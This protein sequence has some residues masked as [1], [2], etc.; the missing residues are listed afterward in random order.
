MTAGNFNLIHSRRGRRTKTK[1]NNNNNDGPYE[2]RKCTAFRL[3]KVSHGMANSFGYVN[4][5]A[6]LQLTNSYSGVWL[7][8]RAS[9]AML[10]FLTTH[11]L[12]FLNLS[13]LGFGVP[14]KQKL[15]LTR[16]ECKTENRL[17][18][19]TVTWEASSVSFTI[20]Y[21]DVYSVYGHSQVYIT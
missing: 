19:W 8:S 11:S 2:S 5:K 20:F 1:N 10:S 16:S 12:I 15:V 7:N 17:K 4:P 3:E 14:F 13:R 18:W 6:A 9:K 21:D